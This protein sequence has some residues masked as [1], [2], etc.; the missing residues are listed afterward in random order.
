M[1]GT[2]HVGSESQVYYLG[3]GTSFNVSSIPGYQNLTKNN[4]I[5]VPNNGSGYGDNNGNYCNQN[6]DYQP[7]AGYTA[8]SCV[9]N[10]STGVL[11]VTNGYATGGGRLSDHGTPT[12]NITLTTK[13]YL[14]KG[15]I[16]NAS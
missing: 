9:Y 10:S 12:M 6:E 7:Y 15:K 8:P 14:V 13:V 3:T 4:F 11:T 16:K 1:V 2:T 5:L